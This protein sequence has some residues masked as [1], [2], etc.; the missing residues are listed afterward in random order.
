MTSKKQKTANEIWDEAPAVL[1]SVD[2]SW[3][4]QNYKSNEYPTFT[5]QELLVDL[6]NGK[7]GQGGFSNVYEI[8]G[9]NLLSV[10]D[11]QPQQEQ[12]DQQPQKEQGQQDQQQQNGVVVQQEETAT[13]TTTTTTTTT[14]NGKMNVNDVNIVN[15]VDEHNQHY[16]V[17]TARLIMSQRCMRFGSARYALKR[18]RPDLQTD[19]DYARG[20]LDLAIE[21]K[22]LSVVQHPNIIKMRAYSETQRMEKTRISVD[23]FIVMD[24]LYDTLEDKMESWAQRNTLLVESAKRTMGCFGGCFGGGGSNNSP[25][26][27]EVDEQLSQR[28]DLLKERLLV[29]YDL[30]G[31]FE[32]FHSL[33][34]VY[35]D[36]KPG[37]LN[38]YE[39][40]HLRCDCGKNCKGV[41]LLYPAHFCT[42]F[43][44]CACYD[45][46]TYVLMVFSF[47]L[48]LFLSHHHH[49]QSSS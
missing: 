20:A 19:V 46:Y 16:D 17:K 5:E 15:V 8:I 13:T 35:R 21:I 39:C 31:A 14:S 28:L 47:F 48:F 4:F 23:T 24:R 27:N 37:T 40:T 6:Q 2:K 12:H 25:Q 3:V 9:I 41:F 49:H 30:T 34:L 18:L 33:H 1:E 29:A 26:K 42:F 22:F 44:H 32:Y 36:I 7:L 11:Q 10:G 38:R 43:K 45:I